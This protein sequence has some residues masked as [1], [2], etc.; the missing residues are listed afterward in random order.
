MKKFLL[1][2]I[3]ILLLGSYN[4]VLADDAPDE[5]LNEIRR[6]IPC[7]IYNISSFPDLTLLTVETHI[8]GV[9]IIKTINNTTGYVPY[10]YVWNKFELYAVN[11]DY[12]LT[13]SSDDSYDPSTDTLN[14]FKTKSFC[15]PSGTTVYYDDA[16]EFVEER[17]LIQGIDNQNK[18]LIIA[19]FA[20]ITNQGFT[21]HKIPAVRQEL[22]DKIGGEPMVYPFSDVKIGSIYYDALAYLKN[23]EG[24]SGYPDGTYKPSKSI[25][26]AE[27]TT[28][29]TTALGLVKHDGR[30]C[31]SPSVFSDVKS[32]VYGGAP[33]WYFKPICY[34]KLNGLVS[35]YPDGSFKPAQR[36]NFAEAATI[37]ANAYKLSSQD[38]SSQPWYKNEI[39][40]LERH[41]AIPI[42]I[43]EFSQ[44]LTRGEVAEII[45]RI[46]GEK[47]DLPS[48]KYSQLK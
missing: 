5:D 31:N 3:S 47:A 22:S 25:N 13:K 16:T 27:F 28:I 1:L 12:Y 2:A 20:S 42:T 9:K 35:G 33:N 34:A 44:L 46:A 39:K 40:A 38:S 48:M 6:F 43:K 30:A 18:Q 7:T 37:I 14:A 8:N 24:V 17:Y 29:V 26:R 19:L 36:I 15:D 10:H 41:K 4:I 32:Y 23:L 11:T 45:Y 21:Y